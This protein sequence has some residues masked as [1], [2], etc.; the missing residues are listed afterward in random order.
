[1]SSHCFG[2]DHLAKHRS[3]IK[4]RVG[5]GGVEGGGELECVEGFKK[6]SDS[7]I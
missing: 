7:I 2:E 3:S 6:S 1:M 5:W 4:K